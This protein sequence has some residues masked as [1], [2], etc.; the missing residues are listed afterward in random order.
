VATKG[1]KVF[2]SYRHED[3]ADVAGRIRDWLVQIR[4][5]TRDDIFMDVTPLLLGADFLLVIE[6]AISKCKAVIVRAGWVA[7]IAA[8]LMATLG[9]AL[10]S[11]T[12]EGNPVWIVTHPA[13]STAAVVT[14]APFTAVD[15]TYRFH[16]PVGWKVDYEIGSFGGTTDT[17]C[18]NPSTSE[19]VHI[20]VTSPAYTLPSDTYSELLMNVSPGFTYGSPA[21]KTIG[22]NTWELSRGVPSGDPQGLNSNSAYAYAIRH[23]GRSYLILISVQQETSGAV[24]NIYQTILASFT[25]LTG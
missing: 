25:F 20:F 13:T 11:Q 21:Q 9:L 22:A 12:P 14:Y 23:Q 5:S 16:Y 15:G 18:D 2:I 7:A 4:R 24:L 1:N 17:V 10:L 6:T 8:L 19:I 3:T